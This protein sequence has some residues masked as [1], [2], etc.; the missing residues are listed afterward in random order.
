[1]LQPLET[2]YEG[3]FLVLSRNEK[4]FRLQGLDGKET[5]VSVNCLKPHIP[6][7]NRLVAPVIPNQSKTNL[8]PEK[9]VHFSYNI[10]TTHMY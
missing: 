1:M 9:H 8:K 10:S 4:T 3:L 7:S 2:P 6:T 5:V